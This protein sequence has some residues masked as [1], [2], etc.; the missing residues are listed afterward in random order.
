MWKE[1]AV[2]SKQKKTLQYFTCCKHG[3]VLL[4]ALEN[5]PSE[6]FSLLD[7]ASKD[8][9]PKRF[10]ACIRT[11]NSMFAM[12]SHGAKIDYNVLKGKGPYTFRMHGQNYHNTKQRNPP[13]HFSTF[14][15]YKFSGHGSGKQVIQCQV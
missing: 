2:Q 13:S 1:E 5:P 11:F 4:P 6:L 9:V 3:R 12:T 7:P 8:P 10:Q 14:R 15:F